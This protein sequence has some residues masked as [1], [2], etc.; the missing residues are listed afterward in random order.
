MPMMPPGMMPMPGMPMPGMP[1]PQS[2]PSMAGGRPPTIHMNSAPTMNGGRA[3]STLSPSMANWNAHAQNGNYAASIAPSER[4]NVGLSARYRPVSTAAEMEQP[5]SAN[6]RASTFTSTSTR[7][8]SQLDLS[9]RPTP[10]MPQGRKSV[11]PLGRRSA[12]NGNADEDDDEEGWAELKAKKE[13]KQKGW[14]LRK[15][16]N[17]ALRELYNGVP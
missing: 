7:P 6:R 13:K 15:G 10:P 8:W 12:L 17:D 3:M 4:S 11:S 14:K 16:Q 2:A 1:M 5:N 9:L